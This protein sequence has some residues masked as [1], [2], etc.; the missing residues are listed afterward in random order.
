MTVLQPSQNS[1]PLY[2]GKKCT[3]SSL[4]S[5]DNDQL[6]NY[7]DDYINEYPDIPKYINEFQ[8]KLN[9]NNSI[10]WNMSFQDSLNKSSGMNNF[11]TNHKKDH[12]AN[13]VRKPS[14]IVFKKKKLTNFNHGNIYE[15]N[16][17]K[18][19]IDNYDQTKS[20]VSCSRCRKFKK[21]CS[22]TLPECSTC[23][24]SDELCVFLP[25]KKKSKAST[26]NT[27]TSSKSRT[28]SS[29]S[30]N[31]TTNDSELTSPLTKSSSDCLPLPPI[32]SVLPIQSKSH[33]NF[34]DNKRLSLPNLNSILL[35]ID[36]QVSANRNLSISSIS[37]QPVKHYSYTHG[38]NVPQSLFKKH[39]NDL[40]KILN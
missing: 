27:S 23:A 2:G 36:P 1:T 18:P 15:H 21:K 30:C 38:S 20:K 10:Q 5:N 22:R 31:L 12:K 40:D 28:P 33:F 32:S 4:Q 11:S 25:R 35:P 14:I 19:D 24:S 13:N 3:K 37:S 39:S 9:K 17:S 29:S 7:F 16:L 26:T 6:S 8:V 34:T